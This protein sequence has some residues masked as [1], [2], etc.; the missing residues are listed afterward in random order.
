MA[1]AV[2]WRAARV[3]VLAARARERVA[4]Q[5]AEREAAQQAREAGRAA[6]SGPGRDAVRRAMADI[7]QRRRSTGDGGGPS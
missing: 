2:R 6:L 4:A 3:R 5:L 1:R 7:A